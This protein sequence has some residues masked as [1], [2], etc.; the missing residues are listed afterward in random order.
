[1]VEMRRDRHDVEVEWRRTKRTIYADYLNV[2]TRARWELSDIAHDP[3][4]S[5]AERHR[6]AS[7][8]FARCYEVRD[9]LELYAPLSVVEPAVQ[10]LRQVRAFRDAVRKGRFRGAGI[11]ADE[12]YRRLWGLATDWSRHAKKAMRH[13]INPESVADGDEDGAGPGHHEISGPATSEPDPA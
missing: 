10:Y 4:L 3:D 1:M 5:D 7:V 13:D 9:Q 11:S 6:R 8:V 12:E 2:L